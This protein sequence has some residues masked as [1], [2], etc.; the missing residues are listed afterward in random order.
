MTDL[1][2]PIHKLLS[3]RLATTHKARLLHRVPRTRKSVCCRVVASSIVA[4]DDRSSPTPS[5]P[6][7]STQT[8][9]R[10]FSAARDGA[11]HCWSSWRGRFGQE[12]KQGHAHRRTPPSRSRREAIPS[13]RLR[14]RS[15]RKVTNRALFHFS[16]SCENPERKT[17]RRRRRH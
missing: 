1:P 3:I 2:K 5:L 14:T 13:P 16:S 11:F 17:A 10:T 9:T 4:S 12:G 7:P 15:R 8:H 6:S